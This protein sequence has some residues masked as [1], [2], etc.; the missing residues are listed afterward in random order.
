MHWH[1]KISEKMTYTWDYIVNSVPGS[2]FSLT[3]GFPA[4]QV[5]HATWSIMLSKMLPHSPSKFGSFSPRNHLQLHWAVIIFIFSSWGQFSFHKR[6]LWSNSIVTLDY[7]PWWV[8]DYGRDAPIFL[9]FSLKNIKIITTMLVQWLNVMHSM[10]L[11]KACSNP[12]NVQWYDGYA[13]SLELHP[14][15]VFF[16][17]S[18]FFSS[19]FLL[20]F[21]TVL[22]TTALLTM[23]SSRTVSALIP[24]SLTETVL[25]HLIFVYWSF[26][27]DLL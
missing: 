4:G 3:H 9:I 18:A 6:A 5:P 20:P 7:A 15:L 24:N 19:F 22:W 1:N 10:K 16:L 2:I 12:I 27:L 8:W 11:R 13:C 14:L 17:L 21:A 26:S 23:M 25:V